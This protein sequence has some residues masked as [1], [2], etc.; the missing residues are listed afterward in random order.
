MP[1]CQARLRMPPSIPSITSEAGL[2][3]ELAARVLEQPKPERFVAATNEH[4]W[5]LASALQK[6]VRRGH[7][8]CAVR[9]A[10]M[11]HGIE[12]QY[13][14]R[15]AAIIALE[16]CF[17]DALACALALEANRLFRFRQRLGELRTLAAVV[18]GLAEAV[19]S[20][21]LTDSLIARGQGYTHPPSRA[22][23]AHGESYEAMPWLMRYLTLRGFAHA[24]LGYEVPHV[25]PFLDDATV[26]QRPRDP[27]GDELIAGLPAASFDM[28]TREGQASIRYLRA[29]KPFRPY[30]PQQIAVCLFYVE[31][32]RLDRCLGSLQIGALDLAAKFT[33]YA[34]VGLT[35]EQAVEL[36]AVIGEKRELINCARKRVLGVDS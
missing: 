33:D 12:P 24:Q 22:F 4:R 11:L 10:T 19:K 34:A 6:S 30:T 21:A 2:R 28:F 3:Q 14:W 27:H 7:V 13:F 5:R 23:K 36:K 9:F 16:D 15:R 35:T 17:G 8:H 31:G 25:W 29:C 1:A 26:M 32:G 20:R 18:T